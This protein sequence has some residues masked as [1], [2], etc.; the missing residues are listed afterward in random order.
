M[1][2]HQRPSYRRS[3]SYDIYSPRQ[4]SSR[5]EDGIYTVDV[6]HS[7]KHYVKNSQRNKQNSQGNRDRSVKAKLHR[8]SDGDVNEIAVMDQ[9]LGQG[10]VQ[11]LGYQNLDFSD[12]RVISLNLRPGSY[13]Y[14]NHHALVASDESDLYYNRQGRSRSHR[15]LR[16][17]SPS[18]KV[19]RGGKNFDISTL[20]SRPNLRVSDKTLKYFLYPHQN[21]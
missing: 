13:K 18:I 21:V 6:R 19:R 15:E 8:Q 5:E 10:Q 17:R 7:R 16:E 3:R 4:S 11:R 20:K 9:D 12:D 14:G 1:T 2:S